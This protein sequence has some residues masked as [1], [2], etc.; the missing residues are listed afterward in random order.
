V[1]GQGFT[2]WYGWDSHSNQYWDLKP[3][4]PGVPKPMAPADMTDQ[5]DANS[6]MASAATRVHH[7]FIPGDQWVGSPTH[8]ILSTYPVCVPGDAGCP[9]CVPNDPNCS[10]PPCP[11]TCVV[12][13]MNAALQAGSFFART[14][15]TAAEAGL[16]N[17]ILGPMIGSNQALT[18]DAL[19]YE[20]LAGSSLTLKDI[21]QAGAI[22]SADALL[23]QSMTLKNLY[24]L[25]ASALTSKGDPVS[26][27]AA[28]VL[29][30]LAANASNSLNL[31]LGD[32]LHLQVGTGNGSAA[33][34]DI[35]G[36]DVLHLVNLAAQTSVANGTNLVQAALPITLPGGS[37][38]NLVLSFIEKPQI[39]YGDPGPS[40][41]LRTPPAYMSS[42]GQI[43]MQ[44]NTVLQGALPGLTNKATLP[45]YVEGAGAGS[46]ITGGACHDPYDD[47]PVHTLTDTHAADIEVGAANDLQQMANPH[48]SVSLNVTTNLLDVTVTGGVGGTISNHV[49]AGQNASY[50]VQPTSTPYTFLQAPTDP[51]PYSFRRSRVYTI[52]G[53]HQEIDTA[54][55]NQLNPTVTITGAVGIGLDAGL[56]KASI[57]QQMTVAIGGLHS[58]FNQLSGAIG[59]RIGGADI[60]DRQLD[61]NVPV[62]V[63]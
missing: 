36:I 40:Y 37:S 8:S 58:L 13:G 22:G 54:L 23:N 56:I 60:A 61:C 62:R 5:G 55:V 9:I 7:E 1:Q 43:R 47:S 20:A 51:L 59:V 63:A 4:D 27:T 14:S 18:F 3:T 50:V 19:S 6:V 45:I 48:A 30:T 2:P 41:A 39:Y 46:N 57:Q 38:T 49:S 17:S 15:I 35:A 34:A 29:G 11:G 16:M 32:F 10:P 33:S 31:K 44:L 42:S 21:R 28:G 24:T 52:G 25:T 53:D 26:V 12:K